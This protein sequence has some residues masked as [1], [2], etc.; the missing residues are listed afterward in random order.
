[1]MMTMMMTGLISN[2][3]SYLRLMIG[4]QNLVV[5]HHYNWNFLKLVNWFVH[6]Q[7]TEDSRRCVEFLTKRKTR[8][9][10]TE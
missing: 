4:V 8:V 3:P 9:D 7:C 1:M 2:M 10:V 5:S 6:V